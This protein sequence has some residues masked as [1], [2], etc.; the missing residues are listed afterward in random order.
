MAPM[1]EKDTRDKILKTAASLFARSGFDGV[2][3]RDIAAEAGV[4][5]G[6]ISY[7]FGGKENL[8]KEVVGAGL[9][10]ARQTIL[11]INEEDLLL[12]DKLEMI[13]EEFLEFLTADYS[14]SKII[15]S[16]MLL[17]G[18]RLPVFAGEH[19]AKL[20]MLMRTIIGEAVRAGEMRKADDIL[21]FISFVSFPAYLVF[22]KPIVE[23][24]R[25]EKGYS[26]A[27]IKKAAKHHVR[28]LYEGLG[29]TAKD[30]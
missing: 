20:A 1:D 7:H 13:F 28:V 29:V 12:R 15:I 10:Q 24:I 22:A 6:S 27:F 30:R 18:K 16:E 26:K 14:I 21:V 9:T 17:G 5:I 3:V 11:D 23:L 8:L 2:S 4:N 19:F 25:S